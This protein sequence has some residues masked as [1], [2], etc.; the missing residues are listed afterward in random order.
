MNELPPLTTRAG[1]VIKAL[2][3]H[4]ASGAQHAGQAEQRQRLAACA[5]CPRLVSATHCALCGCSVAR[6]ARLASSECP[7]GRWHAR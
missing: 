2:A 6:K 3:V 5:A 4:V 7:E 1:N